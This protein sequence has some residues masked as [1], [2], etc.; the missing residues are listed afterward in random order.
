MSY[1]KW[2]PFCLGLNVLIVEIRSQATI[3]RDADQLLISIPWLQHIKGKV[4]YYCGMRIMAIEIT[5]NSNV[6]ST[7]CSG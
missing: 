4:F 2:R 5:G 1:A 6:C 7:L 3:R